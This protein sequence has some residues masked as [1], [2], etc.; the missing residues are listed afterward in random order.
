MK[1]FITLLTIITGVLTFSAAAQSAY[2]RASIDN[3]IGFGPRLGYYKGSDAKD[4]N[5]YGGIQA[6]ARLGTIMGVEGTLEY[7]GGNEYGSADFSMRTSFVPIT[8]SLM[9]FVP[10]DRSISPY[11]LGGIGAYYISYNYSD[12][13]KSFGFSDDSS[14]NLGYHFGLGAE[15]PLSSNFILSLD[16]RYLILSPNEDNVPEDTN[17]NSSILTTALIH[18]F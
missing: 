4:G 10:L 9:L 16:Y 18:Y 11:G 14:F 6:R 5:Y 7:R 12:G 8:A 15:F 13:A 17:F 2:D 3:T 1:K